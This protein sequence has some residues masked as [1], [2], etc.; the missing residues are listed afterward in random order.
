MRGTHILFDFFGTLVVYSPSRTEQGYDATHALLRRLGATVSYEGFL[1]CWTRTAAEFD[2]LSDLD[3]HEFS[4]AEAGTA[5]LGEVLGRA[6]D[7]A[8]VEEF[9]TVYVGEWNAGVH[10]LPG[11]AG[12][13]AELSAGHRLAVVSNTHLATLV[14]GHLAAMGLLEAFDA[15]VTSVEVGWRKPHPA[16]Y[17]R[18]LD[19]LGISA[20]DAV[21]VGDTYGPDFAGPERHGMTAFLIDPHRRE[22][23]VP[24]ERRL[25]SVFDL[26]G[27]LRA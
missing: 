13:V 21:F 8:E 7:P 11:L 24:E 25:D 5:F 17:D 6:P 23:A 14:P 3:D 18:A 27:R 1:D 16:I 4:M 26:P 2:R 15:V 19:V 9:V 20:S 22:P 10:Y 12:L